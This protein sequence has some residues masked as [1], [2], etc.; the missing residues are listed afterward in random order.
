MERLRS[1]VQQLQEAVQRK[2]RS[3][4]QNQVHTGCSVDSAALAALTL[5]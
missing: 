2:Q 3:T 1:E 5:Q 4:P